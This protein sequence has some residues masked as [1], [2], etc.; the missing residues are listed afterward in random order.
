MERLEGSQPMRGVVDLLQAARQHQLPCCVASSSSRE[1][2]GGWLRKLELHHHFAH[3][4]TLDDTG[5]VKP[6]PSLF[7]L[8]AEKLNLDPQHIVVLEDSLNGLKAATAAGM[9]CVVVPCAVTR[10]LQFPN[11]W[12]QL[13]SL[14]D[15][16]PLPLNLT[17]SSPASCHAISPGGC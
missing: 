2:V 11:A 8:C 9:R 12:R 6:D 4:V 16:L 10:H 15:F 1:W 14:E 5:R 3:V 13:S 7:L 17:T